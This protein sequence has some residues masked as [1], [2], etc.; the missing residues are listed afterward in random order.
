M[1]NV[2]SFASDTAAVQKYMEC[3]S[4]K[5]FLE[6]AETIELRFEKSGRCGAFPDGQSFFRDKKTSLFGLISFFFERFLGYFR[7]FE[8][9]IKLR[10]KENS[11][12]LFLRK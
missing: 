9:P 12:L 8:D 11:L 2:V 3:N 10:R 4:Y 5:S 1:T 7:D 6:I